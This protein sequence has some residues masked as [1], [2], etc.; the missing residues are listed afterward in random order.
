M[1]FEVYNLNNSQDRGTGVKDLA[2]IALF[3]VVITVCSWISI[4]FAVPF[5]MQ[6]FGVFC[7][8]GVLGGRRGTL[9]VLIYIF[10]GAV[11][12]PV[13]S[14]FKGGFG[15]LLGPTGGYIA[16]FI[17]SALI[18]WAATRLWG[19]KTIISAAAMAAG[20]LLCYAFG[21]AWYMYVYAAANGPVGLFT[22]LSWCVFPFILPDAV[23]IAL[24]VLVSKKVSGIVFGQRRT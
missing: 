18:Y 19:N 13:F 16:G 11:G 23:K 8:L 14:G 22:A 17:L 4:P 9:A 20:L 1:K 6:T 3:A 24:A 7:A 12:L 15:V 10:M 5:T 21:T 2:Y